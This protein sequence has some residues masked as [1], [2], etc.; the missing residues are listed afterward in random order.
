MKL[1]I[2][3]NEDCI[4]G[5]KK[6]PGNSI[7]L[8]IT[9]PPYNI[10]IDYGVWKD[11][12]EWN[13][14]LKWIKKWLKECYRI[15]KN[16]GRICINHYIA[17]RDSEKKDRFPLMDIR[18]IQEQ[19]GFNVS[20]LVI[21]EDKSYASFT[22]WGSWL[23]ASSPHIQ[24]PYE[25]ILISY[26]KQWK[27]LNKGETT[28]NKEDFI[29]GVSGIWNLGTSKNKKVPCVFPLKLPLLCINLLSYKDDVVLDPFMGSGT[30]AVACKQS[31]RKFI[32]FEIN[33]EYIKEAKR[34][35]NK[36]QE[37]KLK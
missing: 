12:L 6:I 29:K 17:F 11:N 13:N 19:I 24:T 5:M 8:I 9:S 18:N 33:P 35:L 27:K 25:G 21:W 7:D 36:K 10:G 20:K 3:Y 15:L 23:S 37:K 30:T 28:I 4:K 31:G 2:I 22:A 34:L 32:G 1:N 26:K 16:D 14:Y